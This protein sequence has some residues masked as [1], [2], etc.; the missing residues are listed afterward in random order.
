MTAAGAKVELVSITKEFK[1]SGTAV[2]SVDLEVEQGEF[3]TLLGPSG[4]GKTTTLNMIAGFINPDSGVVKLDGVDVVSTPVHKRDIGMVFQQFSL[5]PHMTVG[6]NIAFP[7]KQRGM[8]RAEA[9]AAVE[10]VLETVNLSGYAARK[11]H[12]LSGG[13]QQRVAIARAIV[14]GPRLLLMDE[15]LSA[16]DKKLREHLQLEIKR[17]Q[18]DL[19]VT[20]IF[21]THDQEEALLLSDRIVVFNEGHVAQVGPPSEV[22][23]RPSARFVA[24][25]LGDSNLMNGSLRTGAGG[26]RSFVSAEGEFPIETDLAD[27][28]ACLLLRPEHIDLGRGDESAPERAHSIACTVEEIDY[29]GSVTK[30]WVKSEKTRAMFHVRQVDQG[31]STLSL[32]DR[33]HLSWEPSLGHILSD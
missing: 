24:E 22:Y 19:G 17:I 26:S 9:A 7:L 28:D 4:S 18:N 3:I 14:F 13:Q 15:P 5:F 33:V 25:F 21:V 16:L 8:K 10:R 1:T 6:E 2:A 12:E 30:Y 20:C 11:P 32:G 31:A 23:T 27:G 29:F